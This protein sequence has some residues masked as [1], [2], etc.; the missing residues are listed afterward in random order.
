MNLI[1]FG[2]P[3]VGK[4]T[5]A[6]MLAEKVGVPHISTGAI[7]RSA[8]EQGTELGVKVKEFYDKGELVPDELTTAIVVEA[9]AAP[10]QADGFIL[11]G[12][13]RNISQAEALDTAFEEMGI[14]VDRVIYL[15]APDEEITRRM[16][17][18]GRADDT[19]EVIANRLS[20]YRSETAPVLEHYANSGL[21]SEIDGVGELQDVHSRV[22]DGV[23]VDSTSHS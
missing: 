20:V 15:T 17:G 16:L 11:D 14:G 23:K 18:R 10:E 8:M 21:V 1:F 3:G 6:A 12:Y 7:F 2:A 22:L 5:Q 13:P 9:L 4:G 19:E